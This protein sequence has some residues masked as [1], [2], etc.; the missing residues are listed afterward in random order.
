MLGLAGG[1]FLA[2]MAWADAKE[3]IPPPLGMELMRSRAAKLRVSGG[4]DPDT[5]WIGHVNTNTGAPGIAGG[6][7]P[8]HIGRSTTTRAL[9]G[10]SKFGTALSMSGTWDFDRFSTPGEDSLQGWWPVNAPYGSIGPTD[11]DDIFRPWFCLDYGNIGNYAPVSNTHR[12]FGVTGYWHADGGSGQAPVVSVD[13]SAA[14]HNPASLTWAPIAGTKSAWCGLRSHGDIAVVDPITGNAYNS[15]VMRYQAVNSAAQFTPIRIDPGTDANYPGY[16]SQWDQL[17]YKDISVTGAT[18]VNVTFKYRTNMS[19]GFDARHASQAGWFDKN[20]TVT[21]A[22]NDGNFISEAAA[23]LVGTD[24]VDSFMVYVG[25]PN[26]S[27]IYDPNRRWFSEVVNTTTPN[28]TYKEILSTAGIT[29]VSG[30]VTFP[31]AVGASMISGGKTRLVFRIKTNRGFDDEDNGANGFSSGTAGAAIIDD[32]VVS[33]TG[34]TGFTVGFES[35]G[36]IDNN[37]ATA[38]HSTGKPVGNWAHVEN[39]QVSGLPFDDPCGSVDAAVRFCNMYGNVIVL[40]NKDNADKPGGDF[41]S[42]TQDQQKEIASPTINLKNDG[43]DGHYNAMGIDH[44][45]A[46][47]VIQVAYDFLANVYQYPITGNGLRYR[48]QSYPSTQPN[49]VRT[50]G[51]PMETGFFNFFTSPGCFSDIG[52]PSVGIIHPAVDGLVHTSNANGVPDSVTVD[53]QAM[54]R[55]FATN[56]TGLECSPTTG[57]R[58]GGYYD[59]LAISFIRAPAPPGLAVDI[60][61]WYNDAF[62]TNSQLKPV[63]GWPHPGSDTL[64]ANIRS[65]YNTAPQQPGTDIVGTGA[66][67]NIPGDTMVVIA[68]G[69]NVRMDLVFRILPG[70]GNYVQLGNRNSGIARR[71][72]TVPRVA[73]LNTDAGLA[74]HA[75]RFWG[76]YMGNN[77]VYGTG[78]NGTTSGPPITVWD[79]N[80]WNSA[81]VD[82]VE[83][84]FFPITGVFG[85]GAS[86]QLTPGSYMSTYHESDPK[87]TVLGLAKN[88]CFFGKIKKP[89][90]LSSVLMQCGLLGG[91]ISY[92]PTFYFPGQPASGFPQVA[93][94]SGGAIGQTYEYTKIIP[95]GQLT[96]GALV[97]YFWRKSIVGTPL[98][99]EMEPDTNFIFPNDGGSY[100]DFHR[101]RTAAVLPDM[102]KDPGYNGEGMACMLVLDSSGRRATWDLHLHGRL[103]GPHARGQAWRSQR[104]A[105]A[106]GSGH[107]RCECRRR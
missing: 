73:A 71:P 97:Q 48:F 107:H 84:N 102:W 72:D 19:V 14:D 61:H 60:W 64:A 87:Y 37:S 36:D 81:R 51:Q 89:V 47:N 101:W 99:F 39:I 27:G 28:T 32:V 22:A 57:A 49:G 13:P 18:T 56:L 100:S 2:A 69:P 11:L 59:N 83:T 44:E 95:D 35:A 31:V 103:D 94:I 53:I 76:T 33:G 91:G 15:D 21:A 52:D 20:P 23:A 40:G 38:F 79:P 63:V 30:G 75:D 26:E 96:P 5:V 4:T 105:R 16:G 88:R 25:A 43:I 45:I 7:G 6:Y 62:P 55:C 85:S 46:S 1:A 68:S 90:K 24:V 82:T 86:D 9:V 92:P 104:L 8:Y 98:V 17:L 29:N 50:W 78:G 3:A 34:V 41:G 80:R 12:T 74:N 106:S 66:R 58:A 70:V 67:E 93:E 42:N 77:G 65:A 54:S 10:G